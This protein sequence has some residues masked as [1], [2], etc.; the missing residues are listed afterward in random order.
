MKKL[1]LEEVKAFID[2]QSPETKIYLGV[3]SERFNVAGVWYAD[4]ITAIVVHVDGCH[5]CKIFG[6]VTR[7]RDYDQRKDKPAL[8][9][10]NEVY[11]VSE[12]FQKLAEVLEDRYVEVHLDINPDEMYGSSCVVQQAIGYIRG[13]CNVIPLVKPKAFAASYAADRFKSFA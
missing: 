4:Y 3:D 7:E 9:L 13:T 8:R 12:M 2:A 5:G 10:M 1:D 6:E 11:K